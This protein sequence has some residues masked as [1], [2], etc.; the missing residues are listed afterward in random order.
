MGGA[1]WARDLHDP[2]LK[3]AKQQLKDLDDEDEK[4]IEYE[5]EKDIEDKATKDNDNED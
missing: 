2:G 3:K 5:D 1:Q 4:D